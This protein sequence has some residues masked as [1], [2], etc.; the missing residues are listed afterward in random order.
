MNA[1]KTES[2]NAAAP[3]QTASIGDR[4]VNNPI[5]AWT[6]YLST[7]LLVSSF[8]LLVTHY[9][10]LK[11]DFPHFSP[12]DDPARITDE[13]CS[14]TIGILLAAM[15]FTKT[16]G[17]CLY[18]AIF[19]LMAS[20]CDFNRSEYLRPIALAGGVAGALSIVYYA[21][22]RRAGLTDDYN[23]LF[24]I[25]K[26]RIHGR[27]ILSTMWAAA[28]Y[29][30]MIGPTF[31][32]VAVAAIVLF[33]I[34]CRRQQSPLFVAA[35]LG[36]LGYGAFIVYHGWLVPRYYLVPVPLI[37]IA[38]TLALAGTAQSKHFPV[39]LL[40]FA[41]TTALFISCIRQIRTLLAWTRNPSYSYVQAA[42]AIYRIIDRDATKNRIVLSSVSEQ[43]AL[44]T[45]ESGVF[46][47]PD[48]GTTELRSRILQYQPG[49]EITFDPVGPQQGIYSHQLVDVEPI[50]GDDSIH[51]RLLLYRLT[52]DQ[53]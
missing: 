4:S 51:Y 44:L 45:G 34:V 1:P 19:Y 6:R 36:A 20:R 28:K 50:F 52:P 3:A 5:P 35:I 32:F 49:W 11:A 29:G 17:L 41:L 26:A 46:I 47:N 33:L 7:P 23:N 21:I 40:T 12:W 53:P 18:P 22:V 27:I 30:S 9:V 8:L 16:P 25:N 38:L 10:H 39:R 24:A 13:G 31:Y 2:L 37:A 42:E 48:Y 43:M 14:M 15:L